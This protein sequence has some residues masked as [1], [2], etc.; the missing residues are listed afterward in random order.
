MADRLPKGQ[1]P[2]NDGLTFD[3]IVVGAGSAGCAVAARLSESGRFRVLLLEAGDD[4]PWIWL[5][6]PLGA[7]KILLTER[8]LWRFYTE[9]EHHLGGRRMYWPRGRVLGGSSTVNGLLWVRGDPQEYNHWRDL[10]NVGWCY[11]DVLPHMRRIE[12]YA[13][14]ED[15]L[16]G[17]DGPVHISR[18]PRG[19]D[20]LGDAFHD[21]CVEAGIPS[22]PDYNGAQH[23]GVCYLQM[24][25]RRGLRVGG[26]E[27]YLAAARGREN[28]IVQTG[29][30]VRR[31]LVEN[32]EA[33]GVEY[34]IG[35]ELRV[36]NVGREV[37]LSAGA[38]QSPQLLELS[39][40]GDSNHLKSLGISTVTH[41]PGVGENLRDHLQA[42]VSFECTRPVTLNDIL[43]N[44]VRKA[45]MGLKY[46]VRR[47]GPMSACT[48]TVHAVAK[49]DPK[50]PRPDVKIAMYPLSAA[51]PR[52]P[53]KLVLDK[54]PGF[55]IGPFALRP[56]STGSVHIRSPDPTE[57]PAI[58]ANYLTHEQ[59]RRTSIAGLRLARRL[60][61]QPSL[62]PLVVREVRPGSDA[63]SDEA[64][65]EHYAKLG[66][67]S[68]HPIGTCKMG[69]DPMAVVDPE[70]RVHGIG[71]LRIADASIMP[72][73]VSSNTNAPSVMIGE[74]CAAF[75][76][77][78]T[79]QNISPAAAA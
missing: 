3:F 58:I 35:N 23:E 60:A 44:P 76:L 64:L 42:R 15:S 75:I 34:S 16:R 28:L 18:H 59:D 74:R 51:D 33:I 72:T 67:T 78:D 12:T 10:G 13:D 70:L 27:T 38:I 22:T 66:A 52:H 37:I 19:D 63:Q 36:A 41:L 47:N 77:Q 61:E 14:G 29:A 9:P 57:P 62:K 69:I 73:M 40:I 45:W 71:R 31:I 5:K 25:T 46:L 6:V 1:L 43:S 55:A 17:R 26:R 7:G 53:T 48:V 11:D 4:D 68:Y 50:L 54:F 24:N 56:Q 21:A 39:G 30:F 32:G 49:T 65:L 2:A 20:V 79:G 8:C